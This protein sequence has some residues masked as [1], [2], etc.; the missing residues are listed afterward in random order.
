LAE[1]LLF[2]SFFFFLG[3][4]PGRTRNKVTFKEVCGKLD[5]KGFIC[6]FIPVC[7]GDANFYVLSEMEGRG[8]CLRGNAHQ[9]ISFSTLRSTSIVL[10]KVV[11]KQLLLWKALDKIAQF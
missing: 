8:S 7:S 11:Q 2:F 3:K 6:T 5:G 4:D 1:F 10:A 9:V